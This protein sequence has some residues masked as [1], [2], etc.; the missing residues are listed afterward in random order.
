MNKKP[1]KVMT[2]SA[3]MMV[4]ATGNMMPAHTFATENMKS[5]SV[6]AVAKAYHEYEE[7]SLGPEGIKRCN[8]THWFECF[9]NGFICFNNN[10][11]RKC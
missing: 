9:S 2:L 10:K 1:S 6:H 5:V 11:T 3:L 4:F 8:G 7:Y